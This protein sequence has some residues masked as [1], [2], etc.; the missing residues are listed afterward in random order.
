MA[1]WSGLLGSKPAT[2]A[3]SDA[4]SCVLVAGGQAG[5]VED[6]ADQ[7]REVRVAAEH[8]HREARAAGVAPA[9]GRSAGDRG[10]ADREQAARGRR[11]DGAGSRLDIVGHGHGVGDGGAGRAGGVDRDLP[12]DDDRRRR[13]ALRRG[14]ADVSGAVAVRVG[15]VG[16]GGVRTVVGRVGD[17]V[18]VAV[19]VAG[20]AGPVAVDVG[21]AGVGGVGAVVG[22]VGDGVAVAIVVADVAETVVVAVGLPDVGAR[23]QVGDLRAV[24]TQVEVGVAV[25][26]VAQDRAPGVGQD[27]GRRD[28]VGPL[29]DPAVAAGALV[30]DVASAGEVTRLDVEVNM[31][32][33]NVGGPFSNSSGLGSGRTLCRRGT[34]GRRS[35]RGRRS[36]CS[37]PR[38]AW[39][40]A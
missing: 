23:G 31:C 24:V 7:V 26:V 33:A 5:G 39:R 11:A 32:V 25:A 10:A 6:L 17:G 12:R 35:C 4:I 18:A 15:L 14:V 36:A 20:V 28:A 1:R 22:R 38:W 37:S 2:S 34:C 21:L 8:G 9:V 16:V 40:R 29:R 3:C 13:R 30:V 27:V 19:A